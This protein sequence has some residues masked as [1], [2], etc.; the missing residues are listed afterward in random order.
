M[1]YA[2]KTGKIDRHDE[3]EICGASENI[4]AHHDDYAKPFDVVWVCQDC[5]VELDAQ[6]EAG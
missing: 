2:A 3:C 5:H 6:R 1:Y 4:Q